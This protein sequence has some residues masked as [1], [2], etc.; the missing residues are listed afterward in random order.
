MPTI[1]KYLEKVDFYSKQFIGTITFRSEE[2][3]LP[4]G[5]RMA[6]GIDGEHWVL[7]YQ[8]GSHTHFKVFNYNHHENKIFI[9]QKPG[10]EKNLKT[11]KEHIKYFFAHAKAAELVTLLPPETKS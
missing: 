6:L 3:A 1:D 4:D 8:K 5:S 11:F 2:I 9:D 7:V 10:G